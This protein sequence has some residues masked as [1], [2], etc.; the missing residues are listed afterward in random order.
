MSSLEVQ[1]KIEVSI[2][3]LKKLREFLTK[4][5]DHH[6]AANSSNR[7]PDGFYDNEISEMTSKLIASIKSVKKNCENKTQSLVSPKTETG[8]LNK[9][10][11][12]K[13]QKLQ[14]ELA[15]LE[16]E[17]IQLSLKKDSNTEIQERLAD[18][19]DSMSMQI[20]EITYRNQKIE[21]QVK[22]TSEMI[23]SLKKMLFTVESELQK[24]MMTQENQ[25]SE[26]QEEIQRKTVKQNTCTSDEDK[27]KIEE[28]ISELKE[29]LQQTMSVG[30]QNIRNNECHI[31]ELHRKLEAKMCEM[32]ELS[33]QQAEMEKK[34]YGMNLE[35]RSITQEM[36]FAKQACN[37]D[38][39]RKALT[40]AIRATK[41]E[42][43]K[44][45]ASC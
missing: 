40:E 10:S 1:E 21:N 24:S 35:L 36:D 34:T 23:K 30:D 37:K 43:S 33:F 42:I 38:P 39:K 5:E 3:E 41:E 22:S 28:E 11:E 25:M 2:N 15:N 7:V 32:E 17:L 13:I 14:E 27:T 45:Q 8:T 4:L 9:E 19:K 31:V 12:E 6:N 18:Q 29:K 44:L 26:M 20:T 16:Q